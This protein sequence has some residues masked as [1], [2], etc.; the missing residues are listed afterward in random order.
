MADR[1]EELRIELAGLLA[2]HEPTLSEDDRTHLV[3]LFLDQLVRAE[4][5]QLTHRTLPAGTVELHRN[6]FRRDLT[7]S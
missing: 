3:R 7:R 2:R 4:Q 5:D 1:A 6:A